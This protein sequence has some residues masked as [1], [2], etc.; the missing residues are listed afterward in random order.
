Q[1]DRIYRQVNLD[2][3]N[4]NPLDP[5]GNYCND[6]SFLKEKFKNNRFLETI[7]WEKTG[8]FKGT[9]GDLKAAAEAYQNA[10]HEGYPA[11][12]LYYDLGVSLKFLGRLPEAQNA[13]EKSGVFLKRK[14]N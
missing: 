14:T 9:G 10:I 3:Q 8:F 6:F 7:F 2:I 12:H 13:F 1:A 11:A 4:K 5:W